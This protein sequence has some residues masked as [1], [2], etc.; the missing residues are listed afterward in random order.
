[1]QSENILKF[2]PLS[3]LQALH[4]PQTCTRQTTLSSNRYYVSMG[5]AI[6][7]SRHLMKWS[8]SFE[9]QNMR[10]AKMLALTQSQ[11]N[12]ALQTG[13]MHAGLVQTQ[14]PGSWENRLQ[15]RDD[16]CIQ[17]AR[18]YTDP[19]LDSASPIHHSD[20]FHISCGTRKLSFM[21]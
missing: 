8:F 20:D 10:Q 6:A 12:H 11:Q 2:T 1:M 9:N 17:K 5:H 16:E 13:C 7:K 4:C 15:A 18:F 3:Q 21:Q 14:A 19:F